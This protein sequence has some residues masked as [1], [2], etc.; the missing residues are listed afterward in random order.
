MDSL[1]EQ[2]QQLLQVLQEER[3]QAKALNMEALDEL[4][5]RKETLV[6]GLRDMPAEALQ[7]EQQRQ[8]A[9]QIRQENRR[10]AYLYWSS[11][12]WI[13]ESMQFFGRQGPV[14]GYSTDGRTVRH[15][16]GVNL[17]SGRI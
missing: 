3:R 10:N 13:R 15:N 6:Q 14:T 9:Q 12:Q 4:N 17:L 11:L 5:S 8:L 1:T 2:M 16:N 7:D